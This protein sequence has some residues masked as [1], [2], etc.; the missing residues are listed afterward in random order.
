MP[1]SLSGE[2]FEWAVRSD[3]EERPYD[4]PGTQVGAEDVRR[5]VG[6]DLVDLEI[7]RSA[8]ALEVHL[9]GRT[10]V[11]DPA[12]GTVGRDQP[13]APVIAL[14]Q[15]HRSRMRRSAASADDR[16]QVHASGRMAEAHQRSNE[17]VD[18]ASCGAETIGSSHGRMLTGS[19]RSGIGDDAQLRCGKALAP[20][21]RN[22]PKRRPRC[23]PMAAM[24][25]PETIGVMPGPRADAEDT[26]ATIARS[27]TALTTDSPLI[28]LRDVGRVYRAGA[29]E[30]AALECVD[31]VVEA[32]D[33]VAIVG[34]SGSGK[35]T[36]LNLIT[37]ID[38]PTSGPWLSTA[39]SSTR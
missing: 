27:D 33:M 37:G 18:D 12:D 32:G 20:R 8:T 1:G 22:N 21:T 16:Q 17:H 6:P 24:D 30:Y 31:L 39:S 14:D 28:E 35:T 2:L 23:T 13:A 7:L 26:L 3:I 5:L 25:R 19:R 11:Q 15:G 36:I 34:P 10:S 9:P 29:V 4:T 38:R